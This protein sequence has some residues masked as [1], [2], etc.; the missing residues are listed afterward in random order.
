MRSQVYIKAREEESDMDMK[1]LTSGL[2]AVLCRAD[3]AACLAAGDK[4]LPFCARCSGIYTGFTASFIFLWITS[5]RKRCLHF[6]RE[7][8]VFSIFLFILFITEIF[9]SSGGT[10]NTCNNGRFMIG[11]LGGASMGIFSF[12][13]LNYCLREKTY[14]ARTFFSK[15]DILKLTGVILSIILL[16]LLCRPSFPFCLWAVAGIF[17]M[18]FTLT[19][20]NLTAVAF[21]SKQGRRK[22]CQGKLWIMPAI[23]MTILELVAMGFLRH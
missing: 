1:S 9:L 4:I 5:S 19:A 11:T 10:I 8:S 16:E 12:S 14:F 6:S 17:S 21:L 18:L 2:V 20:A 13:L 3:P 7:A 22:D 23:A 15:G